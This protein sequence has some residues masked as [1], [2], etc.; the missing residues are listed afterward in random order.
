MP[1]RPPRKL[2]CVMGPARAPRQFDLGVGQQRRVR[3]QAHLDAAFAAVGGQHLAHALLRLVGVGCGAA[4]A[5]VGV[6]APGVFVDAGMARVVGERQR[7]KRLQCGEGARVVAH[8]AE[9]QRPSQP[10]RRQLR[11]PL[12]GALKEGARLFRPAAF[13]QQP[14]VAVEHIG[15]VGRQVMR[16]GIVAFGR[17]VILLGVKVEIAQD[18]VGPGVLGVQLE[19]LDQLRLGRRRIAGLHVGHP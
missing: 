15:I 2:D 1:K 4:P 5:Q 19:R 13:P 18:Q 12:D 6:G 10:R 16:R 11:R 14:G 3:L 7:K 9:G 8:L 17:A